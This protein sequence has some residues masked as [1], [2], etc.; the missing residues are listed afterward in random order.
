MAFNIILYRFSKLNNSDAVPG[1]NTASVTYP[2]CR[3]KNEC[4]MIN[5]VLRL[6]GFTDVAPSYNYVY[7]PKMSRYYFIADKVYTAPYW[8]FYCTIDALAS[9]H[10]EIQNSTQY[11]D[12]ASQNTFINNNIID[13][14][15]PTTTT[16][17]SNEAT[18]D[19]LNIEATWNGGA[20]V[21]GVINGQSRENGA[22]T[23][24]SVDHVTMSA[25]MNAMLGGSS[26]TGVTDVSNDLLKTFFNPFEYVVSAK[27]FPIAAAQFPGLGS[28]DYA[29]TF[30][31]GWWDSQVRTYFLPDDPTVSYSGSV[32]I[33]KHPQ[34]S[35]TIDG[36][37][38]SFSYLQQDPYSKYI[39]KFG[40]F[41][42]IPIDTTLLYN[43]NTLYMQVKIDLISGEAKLYLSTSNS[44][45]NA[46]KIV[47]ANYAVDVQL[48]QISGAVMSSAG[49]VIKQADAAATQSG[50]WWSTV[51][52]KVSEWWAGIKSMHIGG[53]QGPTVGGVIGTVGGAI[54]TAIGT[55]TQSAM[56]QVQSVGSTGSVIEYNES[57]RLLLIYYNITGIDMAHKGAPVCD[58]KSMALA[59]GYYQINNP[60]INFPTA[61][62]GEKEI[63]MQHMQNG[64]YH[65]LL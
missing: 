30:K 54:G 37:S 13:T 41:G 40:P 32:S 11:V 51:R 7:I 43:K 50:G 21:I 57:P 18:S 23:Y 31:F 56:P 52:S 44:M 39:L 34:I 5:P 3:F 24:Y 28:N 35:Q 59:S 45:S 33:P 42:E 63:I 55:A 60:R 19:F 6:S 16:G 27:W 58:N 10:N 15:Y 9:F 62:T 25:V 47:R 29:T 17:F 2:N 12:R 8:D 4:S 20:F 46:F 53:E 38:Y 49:T 61:T 22:V 26:Y 48:A 36:S 1:D 65:V 64:F 14:I